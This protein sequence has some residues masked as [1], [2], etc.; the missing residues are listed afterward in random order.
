GAGVEARRQLLERLLPPARNEAPTH[1]HEFQAPRPGANDVDHVRRR[2]IIAW[3]EI[4]R[5]ADE[6]GE[7]ANL[8]PGEML[9]EPPAHA[10]KHTRLRPSWTGSAALYQNSCRL[11][12]N[13]R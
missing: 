5:L 13:S 4:A 12:G 11:C 6:I 3:R 8:R 10:A 7:P 1:R 9:R 2:E